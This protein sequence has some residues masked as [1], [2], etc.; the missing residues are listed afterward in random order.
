MSRSSTRSGSPCSAGRQL[1]RVLAQFRRDDREPEGRVDLLLAPPATRRSPRKTPYSLSLSP[2]RRRGR[3]GRCCA[4]GSRWGLGGRA[5]YSPPRV[6]AGHVQPAGEPRARPSPPR[7]PLLDPVVAEEPLHQP[8]PVG[9]DG[10][11]VEVPDGLPAPPDAPGRLDRRGPSRFPEEAGERLRVLDPGREREPPPPRPIP[12]DRP[13]EV[14]LALPPHPGKLL[15]RPAPGGLFEPVDGID[16]QALVE[17]LDLF[18]PQP[19]DPQKLREAAR[20]LPAQIGEEGASPRR[21][22]L[23]HL[24]RD[25]DA[26]AGDGGEIAPLPRH[27][28]HALRHIGDAPRGGAV[29]ADPERVLPEYVEYVRDLVEDAGDNGVFHATPSLSSTIPSA[30][31]LGHR[32]Q[33]AR[34]PRQ[35]RLNLLRPLRPLWHTVVGAAGRCPRKARH[36]PTFGGDPS[37]RWSPRKSFSPTRSRGATRSGRSTSTIW[38]SSRGS[39]RPA[40]PSA[41]R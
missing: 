17:E 13:E 20:D 6:R 12:A 1:P 2:G 15:E 40:W 28:R 31:A 22:D 37:C 32:E 41:P 4:P 35:P 33:D 29:R 26:D 25:G 36:F 14:L 39:S 8:R 7:R 10:E 11:D 24:L 27:R 38:R 3:A 30:A 5:P 9:R 19:L 23:P 34:G 16:P 18:R 21:R